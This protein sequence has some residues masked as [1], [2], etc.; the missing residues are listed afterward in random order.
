MAKLE[1]CAAVE[2]IIKWLPKLQLAEDVEP[3]GAEFHQVR[4]AQGCLESVI[5]CQELN[6]T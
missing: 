1:A 3:T 4:L 2:A 6:R 5:H